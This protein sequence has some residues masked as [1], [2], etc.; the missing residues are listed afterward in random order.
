MRCNGHL[1]WRVRGLRAASLEVGIGSG[2]VRSRQKELLG[3]EI[4]RV[5]I[6]LFVVTVR[7][8]E[9]ILAVLDGVSI[10]VESGRSIIVIF[11]QG[12]F[13]AASK[14]IGFTR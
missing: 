8:A 1:N 2:H 4:V 12:K 10:V 6:I 3:V 5:L 7:A 11:L 13:G 9:I 14:S